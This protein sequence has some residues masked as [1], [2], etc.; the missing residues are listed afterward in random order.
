MVCK[1][2][3][4]SYLVR[5]LDRFLDFLKSIDNPKPNQV[6]LLAVSGGVD[7][8]VLSHLF[9]KSNIPFAIA[10]CN[11]QLRGE[12]SNGDMAFVKSL[13]ETYQVPFHCEVFD[14]KTEQQGSGEST[15]MIARK[16]RYDWFNE[17]VKEHHYIKLVTA[18]HLND[19]VETV[20]LNTIRG[21]GVKGLSGIAPVSEQLLRPLLFATKTEIENF[22]KA[23][24]LSWREDSSNQSDKY[25]RNLIRHHA[26]DLFEQLNPNFLHTFSDNIERWKLLAEHVAAEIKKL[27]VNFK[28]STGWTIEEAFLKTSSN[29]AI[30]LE[31]LKE[32]GFAENQFREL[33]EATLSGKQWAAKQYV[34]VYDRGRLLVSE[35]PVIEDFEITIEEGQSEVDFPGG[36]LTIAKMAK[37]Q[38]LAQPNNTA[39]LD[40]SK[41]S[42]PLTLRN[43][44]LGDKFQPF[45]M[46]GKKKISDFLIDQKVPIHEK[47]KV[48]VLLSGNEICWV[49]GWRT[50]ERFK[51]EKESEEVFKVERQ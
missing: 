22:A 43:W 10:H 11:F 5:M 29:H 47:E 36:K 34:A 17:L 6:F 40:F 33:L 49:V 4:K 28:T 9:H 3:E 21:T 8:V 20:L 51:V 48:L 44:Q 25:K 13:A 38:N 19:N 23:E 27:D 37:P 1:T 45:G 46:K 30:L 2:K 50:D 32:K 31:W 14:T 42:F 24:G 35:K 16:L 7:S 39:L 41:L 18:H 12:E 15:Q 26:I